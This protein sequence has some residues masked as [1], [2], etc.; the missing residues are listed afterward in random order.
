MSIV[1][2]G[3]WEGVEGGGGGRGERGHSSRLV[4]PF[5]TPTRSPSQR[6]EEGS[7][8]QRPSEEEEERL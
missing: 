7:M 3:G 6:R 4:D 8:Y 2:G 1:G 5:L